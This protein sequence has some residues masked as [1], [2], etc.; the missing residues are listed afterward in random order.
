MNEVWRERYLLHTTLP[1]YRRRVE[2]ARQVVA[3]ALEKMARPY[4]AFSAG[5]DSSV[6]LHLVRS[7]APETPAVFSDDEWQFPETE[8]LVR[9]TPNCYRV[10]GEAW[11]AEWFTS[12][13]DGPRQLPADAIWVGGR[14]SGPQEFARRQRYDGVFIGLRADENGYRRAHL[15]RYGLLFFS[16]KDGLWHANPI[17]WWRLEDV[18]G[19]ILEYQVPYNRAYDR[20][21][22]AGIPPERQRVGPFAVE[23]AI[24]WG[25]I[26]ILR[27]VWPELYERFVTEHPEAAGYV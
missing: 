12:W 1:S 22:E 7:V 24:G 26:A 18:W 19:Y 23:R 5:K 21:F 25:Q 6:V 20:M 11:H 14:N 15:R 4:V 9:A 17:G 3:E 8:E 2:R 16:R 27:R 10:A 13:Q